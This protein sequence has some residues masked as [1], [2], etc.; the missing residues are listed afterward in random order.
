VSRNPL[1]EALQSA[2]AGALAAARLPAAE[3]LADLWGLDPAL[4]VA[5]QVGR[6]PRPAAFL[7]LREVFE[8]AAAQASTSATF[9]LGGTTWA[10]ALADEPADACD[11]VLC[12]EDW[13]GS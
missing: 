13:Q 4:L 3:D 6:L 12:E 9:E 1:S 5:A 8:L 10:E 2:V 7:L 11:L